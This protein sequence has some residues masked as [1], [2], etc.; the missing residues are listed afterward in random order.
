MYLIL[1][2]GKY[3]DDKMTGLI[4]QG[5]GL[6]RNL[7]IL[8][9]VI[10]NLFSST[11]ASSSEVSIIVS[12]D[13]TSYQIGDDIIITGRINELVQGSTVVVR[14][15]APTG[16]LIQT[17]ALTVQ[18]D[19]SFSTIIS[20]NDLWKNSG[21][22]TVIAQWGS[23]GGSAETTFNF[24]AN[25]SLSEQKS[26]SDSKPSMT[27]E[28][29]NEP[30][31]TGGLIST[32]AFGSE[33]APQVQLLRETRD[34]IVMKTRSGAAFMSEFNSV[35]YSFSPIVADWERQ[36][37]VFKEVVKLGITPLITTL[38]IL[39]YVDIESEAEMIGYGIGIILLNV[40]MYFV[41]PAFLIVKLRNRSKNRP[42]IPY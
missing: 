12:T 39:N 20:T 36:N 34:N 41:A 31:N 10:I 14:I 19:K 38:S 21:M 13:K 8:L 25:R 5:N 32:A 6:N 28:A 15:I 9:T 23:Q 4:T 29:K 18:P 40:G 30:P 16:N 3:N 22:Y 42:I 35:Y 26:L 37:P 24:L 27:E 17:S 2:K 33:L 1:L 11:A 7:A